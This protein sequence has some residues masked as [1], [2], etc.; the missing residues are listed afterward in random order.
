LYSVFAPIYQIERYENRAWKH[1]INDVIPFGDDFK[2]E[3]ERCIY[4]DGLDIYE[5]ADRLDVTVEF[6]KRAIQYYHEKGE[7]W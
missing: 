6:A 2:R 1:T 7:R 4:A 5:L 3:F